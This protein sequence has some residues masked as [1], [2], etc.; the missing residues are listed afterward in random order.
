MA[1][2]AEWF[3]AQD[4]FSTD[5]K[6]GSS[7]SVLKGSH[8][9]RGHEVVAKDGGRGVLFK[10]LDTG[11]AEEQPSSKSAKADPAKVEADSPVKAG[12]KS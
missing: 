2:Q 4:T 9:R 1:S 6:D 5:L 10:P 12:R 11:E 3:E 8:W 7:L